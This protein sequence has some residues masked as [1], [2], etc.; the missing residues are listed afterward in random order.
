MVLMRR[1]SK[2]IDNEKRIRCP[3]CNDI[4]T[5]RYTEKKQHPY[6]SCPDIGFGTLVYLR[7]ILGDEKLREWK[8]NAEK[9]V[10]DSDMESAEGEEPAK[11]RLT[12]LE[13]LNGKEE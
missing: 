11:P 13:I 12:I 1:D 7:G 6:F 3:L 8:R 5:L 4:H 9:S 2:N 10:T